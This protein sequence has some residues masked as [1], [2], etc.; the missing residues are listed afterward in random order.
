MPAAG[1]CLGLSVMTLV[2]GVGRPLGG[3]WRDVELG[4][5]F[6]PTILYAALLPAALAVAAIGSGRR[7]ARVLPVVVLVGAGGLVCLRQPN[8]GHLGTMVAAALGALWGS[9]PVR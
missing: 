7:P 8:F 9:L 6:Q 4:V 5:R 3:A 2:P 1:L